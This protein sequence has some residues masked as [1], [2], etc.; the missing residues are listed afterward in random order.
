MRNVKVLELLNNGKIEDLKKMLQDEIYQESLKGKS[1]AKKR[2]TAMKKYF[3]YYNSG[4]A[5]L[6]KPC[7]VEFEGEKYASFTNGH[8]LALTKEDVGEIELFDENTGTY[9][10]VTRLISF[11]GEKREFDICEVI[12]KA[13]SQSYKLKKSEVG[14]GY[15]Y[16]MKYEDAYFKVGLLDA[17]FGLIGDGKLATAYHEKGPR[18]KLTIL[19][20]IGVAVIMPVFVDSDPKEDGIIVV[21][22]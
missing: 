6:Q 9:P 22:V 1:N 13:K 16:L 10:D 4:R 14:Y 12:A 5:A 20:N 7:M 3:G 11:D 2:Y 8:P 17:T 21:E 18:N 19:T 15:R